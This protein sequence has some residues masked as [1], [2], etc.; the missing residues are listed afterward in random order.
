MESCDAGWLDADFG[1]APAQNRCKSGLIP[2][3][4]PAPNALPSLVPPGGGNKAQEWCNPLITTCANV[5][6]GGQF[7]LIQG[8]ACALRMT[9]IKDGKQ[10]VLISCV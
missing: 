5:G 7:G 10:P 2:P 8:T 3:R 1:I 9:W 4:F 6:N